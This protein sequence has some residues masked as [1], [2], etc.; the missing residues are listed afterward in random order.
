MSILVIEGAPGAIDQL[1]DELHERN[2]LGSEFQS[3]ILAAPD[4]SI[5]NK[6]NDFLYQLKYLIKHYITEEDSE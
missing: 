5:E 4:L 6:W 1:V 3:E 2:Y